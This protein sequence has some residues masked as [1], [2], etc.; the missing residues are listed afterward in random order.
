MEE[1]NYPRSGQQLGRILELI[2]EMRAPDL[3]RAR[4]AVHDE[5]LK[6]LHYHGEDTGVFALDLATWSGKE[7]DRVGE[8]LAKLAGDPEY[9][10]DG[11]V[12][13]LHQMLTAERLS[14]E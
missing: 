2:H 11:C 14:R 8:A 5:W 7:L 10:D 6:R 12:Q 1:R 13:Q 3:L 4:D 9:A